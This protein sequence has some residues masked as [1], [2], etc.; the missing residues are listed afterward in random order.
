MIHIDASDGG[1]QIFRTALGLSVFTGKAFTMENIRSSRPN[2]GLR[3]QHLKALLSLLQLSEG[4]CAG[5]DIG[6]KKVIF[7]PKTILSGDLAVDIRTAGSIGLLLQALLI[8]TI[9]TDL[10]VKIKGGGTYGKFAPPISHLNNVLF[11]LLKKLGYNVETEIHHHGFYPKGGARVD[12]HSYKAELKPLHIK[13]KGKIVSIKGVSLASK[14]LEKAQ[15]AERQSEKAKEILSKKFKEEINIETKYV[16]ALNPGSGIQL[17]I[18]TENSFF[19]GDCVG[20]KGKK[21]EL[22]GEEAANSLI[23]SFDNGTVDIHTADMLLPYIAIAG[24][25]YKVPELTNHIK[26]NIKIIE[27]FLDL[28]FKVEDNFISIS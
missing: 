21:A 13:E 25:S 18:E 22:V 12:V 16:D 14:Q 5:A 9:K 24:G 17:T 1:G 2:P 7:T 4:E 19:G 27:Q 11:P 26:T 28:K 10:M 6:S 20:E 15:V 23:K 3:E 8:P